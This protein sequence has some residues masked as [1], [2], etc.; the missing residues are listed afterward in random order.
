M[1]NEVAVSQG[2]GAGAPCVDVEED[3]CWICHEVGVEGREL[4]VHCKCH[5]LK[6]H[7]DCIA[8]WQLRNAG[9]DAEM[10]CRLCSMKLPD[11]KDT[12]YLNGTRSL[13]KVVTLA[14]QVN[15]V[16][17]YMK[18]KLGGEE[19]AEEFK[20]KLI[21]AFN[22]PCTT[23]LDID[24]SV[25]NPFTAEDVLKLNGIGSY[26]AAIHCGALIDREED[27][28]EKDEDP[29]Q[30]NSS[31]GN[32]SRRTRTRTSPLPLQGEEEDSDTEYSSNTDTDLNTDSEAE[33]EEP[34]LR[35][36]CIDRYER[37]RQ[38]RRER[39]LREQ[40][41]LRQDSRITQEILS[42]AE[43]SDSEGQVDLEHIPTSSSQAFLS[44]MNL[45]CPKLRRKRRRVVGIAPLTI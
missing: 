26:S 13:A 3:R 23:H 42:E 15:G 9:T 33:S 37:L 19:K 27:E 24:F 28:D 12:A 32:S 5:S 44:C 29:G 2:V 21:R 31:K 4:H 30:G 25:S 11:W 7:D 17:K 18:V 22:L 39:I 34:N 20:Q 43:D 14:V 38:R 45:L 40:Q 6:A 10:K 1:D 35:V 41:E 36:S 16:T 8:H